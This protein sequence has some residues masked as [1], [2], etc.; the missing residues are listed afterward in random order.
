MIRS[1]IPQG[2]IPTA[3]QKV[4]PKHIMKKGRARLL[5][6]LALFASFSTFVEHAS[7]SLTSAA[8]VQAVLPVIPGSTQFDITGFA[9]SATLD[10]TCVTAAGASLDGLGK[11]AV[12]HCGGTVVLNGTSIVIP[13]ETIAVLPASALTWQELFALAPAPWGPTQTGMAMADVPAPLTT[14]EFH[15]VGNRVGAAYIAGL[16]HVSQQELNAGAG[17]INFINYTD[18]SF[19]VGGTLGV[20]GTGTRVRINDPLVAG[21][22]TGR[23]GRPSVGDARFQ[24]DQDNPTITAGTGYPMCIPRVTADPNIAPNADDPLCP[25]TNRPLDAT[26]AFSISFTMNN[27]NSLPLGGAN[28]PRLQAPMEV[29][30][31][32]TFSGNTQLDAVGKFVAAHTVTNNAAIYTVPGVDPAYVSVDVSLLGTGGLTVLGAGEATIRTRFEGMTTDASRRIY[33]YGVD[34]QPNGSSSDRYWGTIQPDPGPAGGAGAVQGRWRFRPPCL[35]FGVVPTKPQTECVFGPDNSFLPA[36]REVRAVIASAGSSLPAPAGADPVANPA[37]APVPTNDFYRSPQLTAANGLVYGQYHAPIGDFLF[38]ENV[39]GSP[40]VENNFNSMPFLTTG[41]YQSLTGVV[42]GQ[43]NPW[44]SNVL[45]SP[46]T[47]CAVLQVNA[48]GPYVVASG[49]TVALAAAVSGVAPGTFAWAITPTTAGTFGAAG[50]SLAVSPSPTPTFTANALAAGAINAVVTVA[51]SVTSA[52]SLGC[53]AQKASATSTITVEAPQAVFPPKLN[54][55]APISL[56]SGANG[57]FS[58]ASVAI[59]KAADL[60]TSFTVVQTGLVK[61][62]NVVVKTNAAAGS[63]QVTF[64]APLLPLG[65]VTNSV[66]TLSITGT[67]KGGTSAAVTTT[68]TITPAPDAP[69]I[70]SAQYR[71]GK[72]RLILIASSNVVS[73]NV[74]L[75]LQPY[76]TATGSVYDP[77]AALGL[78]AATFVNGGGGTYTM[79][80]VGAPQPKLGALTTDQFLRVKSN[81]NGVSTQITFDATNVRQ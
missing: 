21:T 78:P 63:A 27:P 46:G 66:V 10:Q 8:F 1:R 57:A 47:P 59:A 36:T 69:A 4:S 70:T 29:G 26:G 50:S 18:G 16:V 81:L 53:P 51:L 13:K 14:Y 9:Q 30:D 80:L 58:V 7:G 34:Q 41:G 73:P 19:E 55:V 56:L 67:N 49:G 20:S 45:P 5:A 35:Q 42:A 23:F 60:A 68:V 3:G 2:H 25:R 33:L 43:L 65:Q 17:Y 11:P 40:I 48:G 37:V 74:V 44:P 77:V 72:Q 32:V 39:P 71:L 62:S 31:F 22:T 52:A 79:T 15:V 64:T 61:L 24:V 12:A 54:A 38:P 76:T 75:V 28:D 6:C